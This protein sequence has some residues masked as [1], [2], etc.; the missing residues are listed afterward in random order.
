MRWIRGRI[1]VRIAVGVSVVGLLLALPGSVH[2]ASEL[3]SLS[4]GQTKI[5]EDGWF[6]AEKDG[7]DDHFPVLAGVPLKAGHKYGFDYQS[8]QQVI[9]V[10]RTSTDKLVGYIAI[11]YPETSIDSNGDGLFSAKE[12]DDALSALEKKVTGT[13]GLPASEA[14]Q[15]SSG[16]ASAKAQFED[17]K[18]G[19]AYERFIETNTSL[20]AALAAADQQA[21]EQKAAQGQT[22]PLVVAVAVIAVAV[23]G[24]FL[25]VLIRRR[26]AGVPPV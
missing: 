7:Y 6:Y 11:G 18:V 26:K 23:L 9:E 24:V 12:F 16:V 5:Y 1:A 3:K 17:G 25:L 14:A 13:K 15:A 19:P 2:A 10:R 4:K 21:A 8:P 22:A 20:S